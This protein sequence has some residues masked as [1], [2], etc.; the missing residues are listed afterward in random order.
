MKLAI[1]VWNERVAPVFDVSE[2]CLIVDRDGGSRALSFPGSAPDEKAEF[3]ERC[4]VST[5]VCGAI[6]SE[7]EESLL[8]RGIETVPFVAAS[9]QEAIEAWLCGSLELDRFSMPGCGCP[10][11]RR[12]RRKE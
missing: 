1:S 8:A 5:L 12:C 4:G 2:R 3:L 9:A 6:S 10:R 7:Y 11:R